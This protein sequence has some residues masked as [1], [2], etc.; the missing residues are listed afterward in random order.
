M[1]ITMFGGP[2]FLHKILPVKNLDVTFLFE[3]TNAILSSI[4]LAGGNVV[5]TILDGNH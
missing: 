2:K 4:K 5:A 1:I 3:Q